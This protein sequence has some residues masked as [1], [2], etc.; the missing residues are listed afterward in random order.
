MTKKL[1]DMSGEKS[2]F[3]LSGTYSF[4]SSGN[5][6]FYAAEM[7]QLNVSTSIQCP[8]LSAK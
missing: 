6:N 8:S 5:Q 7:L 4:V 3:Y 2:F 1:L